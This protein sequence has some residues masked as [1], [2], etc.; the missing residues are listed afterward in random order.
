VSPTLRYQCRRPCRQRPHSQAPFPSPMPIMKSFVL[1]QTRMARTVENA[2]SGYVV[3]LRSE[4][5]RTPSHNKPLQWLTRHVCS[6]EAVSIDAGTH[7]PCTSGLLYTQITGDGGKLP[8]DDQYSS[9]AAS[10][11][12]SPQYSPSQMYVYHYDTEYTRIL[13]FPSRCQ[14]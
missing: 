1:S 13:R 14:Q 4:L 6:G 10:T 3:N 8:V 7:T 11:T 2:A 5:Q 12:S 9:L